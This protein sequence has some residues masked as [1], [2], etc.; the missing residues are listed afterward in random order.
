MLVWAAFGKYNA[1]CSPQ[2]HKQQQT[3]T[4]NK[5]RHMMN[6]QVDFSDSIIIETQP[7]VKACVIWL[8][9][10]GADGNDF[11]P[12]TQ[13][14]NLP[15]GFGIRFIFPHAPIRPVTLNNNMP[16]RAWFDLHSL[17]HFDRHDQEGIEKSEYGINQLINDQLTQ[18]PAQK[19]LLAGFSQGGAMALFAGLRC[20]K[21]LA[22]ILALSTY[23][24]YTDESVRRFSPINKNTP[25]FMAHGEHDEVLPLAMGEESYQHLTQWGY[26]V[27]WHEYC[28]AHEVCNQELRDISNF[29]KKCLG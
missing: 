5:I 24:P 29:I 9:G 20:S 23:F 15:A 13:Q 22:G 14:L 1:P 11:V 12:I 26:N 7:N 25:I 8:H 4:N 28:M 10:L 6:T 17:E 27:S 16:M 18:L 21:K 3:I 19:I 2:A